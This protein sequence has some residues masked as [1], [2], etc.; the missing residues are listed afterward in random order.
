MDRGAEPSPELE[1]NANRGVC[2]FRSTQGGF[3]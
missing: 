2:D 1:I 3:T